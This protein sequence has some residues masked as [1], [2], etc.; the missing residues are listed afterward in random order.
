MLLRWRKGVKCVWGEGDMYLS[1]LSEKCPLWHGHSFYPHAVLSHMPRVK[2]G[3]SL[4]FLPHTELSSEA[5]TTKTVSGAHMSWSSPCCSPFL[6]RWALSASPRCLRITPAFPSWK[7]SASACMAQEASSNLGP[8]TFLLLGSSGVQWC[9]SPTPSVLAFPLC[10]ECLDLFCS[11]I[12][13][14]LWFF[15]VE[16][17]L[18]T[19]QIDLKLP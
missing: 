13:A 16:V 18:Q 1:V 5:D 19:D 11:V 2:W 15:H 14:F 9:F 17:T 12:L 6:A 8:E 3:E 7:P 4:P 10:F